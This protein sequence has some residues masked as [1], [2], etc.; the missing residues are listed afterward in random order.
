LPSFWQALPNNPDH[1]KATLQKLKT[2]MQPGKLD[3]LSKEIFALAV[4]FTNNCTC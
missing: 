1:L 4:S 2:S 3:R